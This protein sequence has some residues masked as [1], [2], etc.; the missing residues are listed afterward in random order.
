MLAASTT[1]HAFTLTDAVRTAVT[2]NPGVLEAAANRRSVDNELDQARGL[3]LP[4][5]D[6]LGF[7]GPQYVDRPESLAISENKVTRASRQ[8][9]VVAKQTLFD[10]FFRSNEFYRQ[11]SR[12]NSAAARVLE[13][14]EL[15]A[16]DAIEAF[17]DL[18]RHQV[19]LQ[20][21]DDNIEEHK[22]LLGTVTAQVEVGTGTEG[23]IQQALERLAVAEAARAEILLALGEVQARFR[24]VVG[25]L[26][27]R[28]TPPTL[29]TSTPKSLE[30]AIA[31]AR[32]NNPAL[33]AASSDV[34]VAD[35][36][37]QQSK[38]NFL[39]RVDLE[40]RALFGNDLDGI[41]GTNN[42]LSV[43]LVL[44]WN[45]FSGGINRAQRRESAERLTET[46]LRLDGLRR[47]IDEAAERAYSDVLSNDVRLVALRRQVNAAR[48][49]RASYS[50]EYEAGLRTV[51][52]LLDA[53]ASYFNGRLRVT[54]S[55]AIAI[56]SRYQ[57]IAATGALLGRFGIAAPNDAK[58]ETNTRKFHR[59]E[60]V[61]IE[62]LRKW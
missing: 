3:Y 15:I 28:I 44:N 36:E 39:P 9:G 12:V 47:T 21:A 34:D 11:F 55:E 20:L 61:V 30:S 32:A 7:V 33:I 29:P 19:I 31:T 42:N 26:P 18:H 58:P 4:Q 25:S 50:S 62:P 16:L 52:D 8:I 45:I 17:V 49:V 41:D 10:G 60:S 6:V 23:D 48:A 14:A 40:G 5:V 27:S 53:E 56:F 22:R 24:R 57:L 37:F 59:R 2:T 38:S 51:I 13:R 46:E 1:A 43:R 54:S 35:F